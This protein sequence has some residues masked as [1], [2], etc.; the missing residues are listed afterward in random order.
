MHARLRAGLPRVVRAARRIPRTRRLAGRDAAAAAAAAAV[1]RERCEAAGAKREAAAAHRAAQGAE[2]RAREAVADLEARARA[3]EERA[4]EADVRRD[5][6]ERAAAEAR[7]ARG[8]AA[9]PRPRGGGGVPPR[10]C[11]ELEEALRVAVAEAAALGARLRDSAAALAARDRDAARAVRLGDEARQAAGRAAADAAR[12]ADAERGRLAAG[13][14]AA[15]RA[16]DEA[17]AA[18]AA[19]A[20]RH[21][22]ALAHVAQ[23]HGAALDDAQARLSAEHAVV[24]RLSAYDTDLEV[25]LAAVAAD[26]QAEQSAGLR[27]V[28]VARQR[29]T[30][31]KTAE[32][33]AADLSQQL[34]RALADHD[35]SLKKRFARSDK[36]PLAT[37][38][39][40]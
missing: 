38:Q 10:S 26:L 31:A 22:A 6:A 18:Y 35:A 32:R 34:S 25:R 40:A 29:D 7:A 4:A 1:D 9:A 20:E 8:T 11:E 12:D 3:A 21:R 28:E 27:L 36:K 15:R 5:A 14:A 19:Q 24:A 39:A 16:A 30:A 2:A 13:L 23:D 37:L 33:R 17:Q